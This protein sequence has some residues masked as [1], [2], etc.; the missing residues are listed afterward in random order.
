[1]ENISNQHITTKQPTTPTKTMTTLMTS[2]LTDSQPI[3]MTITHIKMPDAPTTIDTTIDV[4]YD[5]LIFELDDIDED[6]E[7]V[8][9]IQLNGQTTLATLR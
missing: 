3:N 6:S 9:G 8:F 7:E 2:I 4:D 1:M 5:N